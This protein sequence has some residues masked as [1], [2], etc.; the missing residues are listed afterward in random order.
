[1]RKKDFPKFLH[2]LAV[3]KARN[4][5]MRKNREYLATSCSLPKLK[6]CGP[7]LHSKGRPFFALCVMR[8]VHAFLAG[9][10]NFLKTRK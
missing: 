1:M 4:Y 9:L 3:H 7:N 5:N 8:F 2:Y 10:D 6:I